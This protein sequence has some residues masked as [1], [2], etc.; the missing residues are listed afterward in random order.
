MS[1]PRRVGF[2][3][4]DRT[5]P[6]QLSSRI[7]LEQGA[8]VQGHGKVEGKRMN[9]LGNFL[10][11]LLLW[12]F[13]RELG[14]NSTSTALRSYF[15]LDSPIVQSH[16]LRPTSH[17]PGFWVVTKQSVTRRCSTGYRGRPTLIVQP[18]LS[19]K[20]RLGV[21]RWFDFQWL[22]FCKI[23]STDWSSCIARGYCERFSKCVKDIGRGLPQRSVF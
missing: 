4:G 17:F 12:N 23:S 8:M 6:Q 13:G 3:V 22:I 7:D 10:L 11:L 16:S 19:F 20:P 15:Y 1:R 9:M 2:M 18:K 21:V 14:I 5:T